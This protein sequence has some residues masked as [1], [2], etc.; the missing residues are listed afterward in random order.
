MISEA[1]AS[2]HVDLDDLYLRN[3]LIFGFLRPGQFACRFGWIKKLIIFEI[4]RPGQFVCRFGWFLV[5]MS[6]NFGNSEAK[7]RSSQSLG[8]PWQA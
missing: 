8:Q 2:S 4:L 6:I 1:S 5:K 7:A 3:G